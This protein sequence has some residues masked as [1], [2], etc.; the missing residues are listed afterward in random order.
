MS[1]HLW[2][3]MRTLFIDSKFLH[4]NR[5]PIFRFRKRKQMAACHPIHM[6]ANR[7]MSLKRRFLI[8]Q[9][10]KS[11]LRIV[12]DENQDIRQGGARHC[13]CCDLHGEIEP[14]LAVY[15][16][17]S[18]SADIDSLWSIG[19]YRGLIRS[20]PWKFAPQRIVFRSRFRIRLERLVLVHVHRSSFQY[21]LS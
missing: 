9:T 6:R 15:F 2:H 10:L 18:I 1:C 20:T 3:T 4:L 16:H 8:G 14:N 12:C 7:Y 21:S 17:V 13:G 19:I 5:S 11:G